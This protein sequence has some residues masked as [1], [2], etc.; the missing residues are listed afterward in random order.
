MLAMVTQ[1]WRVGLSDSALRCFKESYHCS[2]LKHHPTFSQARQ[3][4]SVAT[5]A[6][7]RLRMIPSVKIFLCCYCT[8]YAFLVFP[9]N[10]IWPFGL[11]CVAQLSFVMD[12]PTCSSRVDLWYDRGVTAKLLLVLSISLLRQFLQ[13]CSVIGSALMFSS[14]MKTSRYLMT[15]RFRPKCVGIILLICLSATSQFCLPASH[16]AQRD[17]S[18]LS[19]LL[20]SRSAL[21]N[22]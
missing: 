10:F 2:F 14:W 16:P 17:A 3:A 18:A 9:P 13:F 5:S 22:S 7:R 4:S 8:V 19:L 20:C 11:K 1:M 6:I 21:Q 12:I 15:G